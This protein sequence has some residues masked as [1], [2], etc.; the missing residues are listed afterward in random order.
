MDDLSRQIA[1]LSPQQRA[2]LQRRLRSRQV[3]NSGIQPRDSSAPAPLSFAQQ[4]LWFLHHLDP[5]DPCYNT[6]GS[7]RILGPLDVGALE[8]SVNEVVRRHE[9][10]RTTFPSVDG[11]P[12]QVIHPSVVVPLNVVEASGHGTADREAE[13]RRLAQEDRRRPFRLGDAPLVRALLVRLDDMDH[14]LVVTMHHIVADAW[15]FGVLSRELSTLYAAFG[16]GRPSPLSD[17]PIQYADFAVWQRNELLD[18]QLAYWRGQ[19]VGVNPLNLP[20]DRPR[21]AVRTSRGAVE[22]RSISLERTNALNALSRR[23]GATPFMTLLAAFDVLLARYT[24]HEDVAVG[25][26]IANRTRRETEPLI[27]CFVNMLVLRT[28]VSGDPTFLELLGRV[29]ETAL[30]AFSNQNVP[31]EKLV[32]ELRPERT[33]SYNPLFQ[34]AFAMQNATDDA[35]ALRGL[36][37]TPFDLEGADARFDIELHIVENDEGVDAS[38]VYST[39]LFEADTIARFADQYAALLEAVVASPGRSLSTLDLLTDAERAQLE[40]WTATLRQ[41][42]EAAIHELF[43]AQVASR[44]DATAVVYGDEALTYAELNR[45][46]NR[47]AHVLRKRGVAPGALVGLMVER[48]IDMIVGMLGILKVGGAYVPLD[49]TYPADRLAFMVSDTKARVLLTHQRL[50]DRVNVDGVDAICLDRDLEVS[51]EGDDRNPP[52]VGTPDQ[53]ACVIYTSG[54]TGRPKG[55]ELPHRGVARLVLGT[56]YMSLGPHSRVAQASNAAFDATT[57]EVWG[58]LLTGGQLIGVSKDVVLSPAALAA[59]LR[60]GRINTLFLTTAL[61]NQMAREAP[62]AFATL[63]EVAFGGEAVDPSCVREVLV[64][65]APRRLVHLYGPAENT[66]LATWHLV[67]DV[68]ERAATVPI[69]RPVAAT[70]VYV[71]G[72]RGELVPIGTPGELYV[73]GDGLARGYLNRP[74]LTAEVFVPNPFSRVPGARLYRTGDLVRWNSS[75]AIE[76]LGRIDQQVKIRGFRIEPAEVEAHVREH[77]AVRDATVVVRD[78]PG[79]GRSLVAYVVAAD[80]RP[81]ALRAIRSHLKDRL[82]EYMIPAGWVRL[83]S[84]P[85]TPNGKIDRNA[86][87]EPELERVSEADYAAPRTPI[88]RQITDI[89]RELLGVPQVGIDDNFFDL[90]GHSLLI[91]QVHERLAARLDRDIRI[92]E[93][94]QY[95]TIRALAAHLGGDAGRTASPDPGFA[96]RPSTD[97]QRDAVAIVG[98]AGRFPGAASVEEFWVRVRDSISGIASFDDDTLAALGV[99]EAERRAPDYVKAFGMLDGIDQFDAGF[100][101]YSAREAELIDPQQRLFLE[102]AWEALENAGCAGAREPVVGVFAGVGANGYIG[103]LAQIPGLLETV[104]GFQ[105]LISSDKDFLATRAAYKLNLTGPAVAVQTACS[106]SLV[107]V[108]L[109]CRS[110]LARECDVALA[111]GVTVSMQQAGYRYQTGGILSPDGC[112]R[113]FDAQANGTV[114]G[115]GLAVVV[116]KRLSDALAAGDRV[117][118]VIKGS[119]IN[120]DGSNKVGFTAPGVE[121]Q[122]HVIGRAL[123][124]AEVS[125]ESIGY[126]EAHGTGTSLGDPIEIQAL[127]QAFRA[128]TDKV[129]YCGIGSVKTSVGHLDAAAG[130]TGLITAALA[131]EREELPPTLHYTAPNPAIDFASSPFHVVSERTP[132]RRSGVPRRAGVSSF[133]I[134]GTNAHVVLEEAPP[135]EA[136]GPSRDHQVLLIS[137]RSEAALEHATDALAGHLEGHPEVPLA[138]VAYTLQT[139]RKQF[140]WRRVLVCRDREDAL[141]ALRTRDPR[142]VRTRGSSVT[143]ARVAFLFPGQGAQYVDMARDL[144]DAEPIFRAAMDDCAN[145]LEPELNCDLRA[146]VFPGAPDVAGARLDD[147]ALAQPALFA[148]EYALAA[149]WR[150]WGV[151][152]SAMLGHSVGE[153]VAA[154]LAGVFTLDDALRVVAARG[155]LMQAQPAGAMLAVALGERALGARLPAAVALAAINGSEACVV[156]GP[157]EAIA[158]FE[159]QLARDNVLARRLSTSHAFHSPM[160][161]P[162][163]EPFRAVMAAIELRAPQIPIVSNVTGTWLT[164]ADA[165]D[166]AYWARHL[167]AAVRFADGVTTLAA[168]SQ[169]LLLEVGPGRALGSLATRAGAGAAGQ[170]AI[171][172]LG[173]RDEA[174]NGEDVIMAGVGELWLRGAA[175]DWNG[176]AANERRHRVPLPTYPFERQRYWLD[177]PRSAPMAPAAGAIRKRAEI[178]DWF[179]APAWKPAPLPAPGQT[180]DEAPCLVF[181]DALDIGRALAE[182]LSRR[183]RTVVT[184]VPG[185]RFASVGDRAYAIDPDDPKQYD[186]LLDALAASDRLPRTIVH[187]WSLTSGHA[188]ARGTS[189]SHFYRLLALGQALGRR[190]ADRPVDVVVVSNRLH[191][192]SGSEPIDPEKALMVGACRVI[193]QEHASMAWRTVDVDVAPAGPWQRRLLVEQ[194]ARE[195]GPEAVERS[196]AYR[197]RQRWA[198]GFEPL[199]L[200][201]GS[202]VVRD[203]GVY[204]ITGGLGRIGLTIARRFAE[205]ARV[206]LALIG[207]SALPPPGARAAWLNA[208]GPDDPV[209]RRLES[210]RAIEQRGADVLVLEADVADARQLGDAFAAVERRHG[211]IVGVVHAAGE[212]SAAAMRALADLDRADCERHFAPKIDGVVALAETL[213]DRQIEF[214]VLMSSLSTV[215]GGLQFTAYAAANAY[216]DAFARRHTQLH[217]VRWTS[218]D[219]DGWLESDTADAPAGSVA[220]L[221]MTPSEGVAAF[222]RVL[223]VADADRLVVSTA[224][225]AERLVARARATA[226]G[227]GLSRHSRPALATRFAEPTNAVEESIGG[228]WQALLGVDHVGINDDFFELGGHSLL[229]LQVI[230]R[231][232]ELFGVE[233]SVHA[234]FNAPTVAG[235]AQIVS[236]SGVDVDGAVDRLDE[237]LTLV[238]QL[239]DDELAA[240]LAATGDPT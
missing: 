215:L 210:I 158:A 216:M 20:T 56:N 30:S 125:P 85:L 61:F 222:E 204:V 63:D 184:V 12:I 142:R 9:T 120:N 187:G 228:V 192:V 219:W 133:G 174:R 157:T 206:K 196:V 170:T 45:K 145:R 22:R 117:I 239:S 132:W 18:E 46:A 137:A 189:R 43:E 193:P 141:A 66:T 233:L 79:I 203:G 140:E 223:H 27:G 188:G 67:Q 55:V 229:A 33:L 115:S 173:T 35:V 105:T 176:F 194:L 59:E 111:G 95:P 11:R 92:V 185:T 103:G 74:E 232:R 177:S 52:R 65:G 21:G 143:S 209:S 182:N 172:S 183:D 122:A 201:N 1:S 208:H 34:V 135:R 83:P 38:F 164:V 94:F 150:A 178:D 119:A 62:G 136:S 195:C 24:G 28:D 217:P 32:E 37:T 90:G 47:L 51:V 78:L 31:F 121:G 207:R 8:A 84:I 97:R 129:G 151:E 180:Q 127:T 148:V 234:V 77:A 171:A 102:C 130:V 10:L 106:T 73:G 149:L 114:G 15:S 197:G 227:T 36:A 212:T 87:P 153:Y 7:L 169:P 118:A 16:E 109:A 144:Y 191:D 167:R 49:T 112:C 155:R 96:A 190:L 98:A 159:Q 53:R 163:V 175:I 198:E 4:R 54:S 88:E 116:L 235:L 238:E 138:D 89:W 108:H 126:V 205:A 179:Y 57:F 50:L 186:E 168:D 146:V 19:L 99:P 23:A 131:L 48:S 213:G 107:A 2:A 82:P 166:P 225:L 236:T 25:S 104:G 3:R 80:D 29:R 230:Q 39:D 40:R 200:A 226:P 231:L 218:V 71:L 139:G 134:G 70:E 42:P 161:E 152:P 113:A 58:A 165:T 64:H 221:S 181:L 72:P 101:G 14:V 154:C 124:A 100:F 123:A 81:D 44:P 110:V 224:D 199:R 13:A 86:L 68:P 6:G 75:G 147:T 156:A 240:R 91:V 162:A 202:T 69:G 211:A 26:P 93:L 237:M 76:F 41:Y 17:L 60:K 160:M 5:D 128:G 220:A 214:C